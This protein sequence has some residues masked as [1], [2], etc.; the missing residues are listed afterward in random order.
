MGSALAVFGQGRFGSAAS[1]LD[2]LVLQVIYIVLYEWVIGQLL[3]FGKSAAS[4][5]LIWGAQRIY[6]NH[7]GDAVLQTGSVFGGSD[8]DGE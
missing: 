7:G 1:V 5:P 3:W 4:S 2:F 6:R 8:Y